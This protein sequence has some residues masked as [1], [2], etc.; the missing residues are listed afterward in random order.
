[1][2]EL[3][4]RFSEEENRKM[5][6]DK[7]SAFWYNSAEIFDWT[8]ADFDKKAKEMKAACITIVCTRGI[9]HFR[10]NY[11]PFWPQIAE[12]LRKAVIAFHR[13]GIK[14][15][16]HHS[17][18]LVYHPQNEAQWDFV[19]GFFRKHF[20]RMEDFPGY[21]ESLTSDVEVEKGLFLSSMYQIDGS[22]G[23]PLNTKYAGH[24][25]C[26]NNPDYNR[27]YFSHL[28]SI[29]RTGVDCINPDDVMY[30]GWD[31]TCTC[32]H[33]RRLFKEETGY[34]LP[35]PEHWNEFFE[36]YEKTEY[37][38]WLKFKDRSTAAFQTRVSEKL[39]EWGLEVYRPCYHSCFLTSNREHATFFNSRKYWS[40]IY[41]E[42]TLMQIIKYSWPRFYIESLQRYAM[43]RT[44]N[45]PSMS[46]FY[47]RTFD[48]YFFSWALSLSWGQIPYLGPQGFSMT[49][50]DKFFNTF[51]EN[52]SRMFLNQR[53]EP[54]FAFLIP[55]S[56]LDFTS[57]WLEKSYY[58]VYAL[59]EAA[60][61]A[62]LQ[63]DALEEDEEQDSFDAKKCIVSIGSTL[64]GKELADKL[65]AYL[66]QGGH[67]II[68][69]D[70]AIFHTPEN[71]D[72]ILSH[73]NVKRFPWKYETK[74][75]QEAVATA[76]YAASQMVV[77]PPFM[78]DYLKNTLGGLLRRELPFPPA[79]KSITSGFH[80]DLFRQ[81]ADPRRL[82]LHVLDMRDLLV[83]EGQTVTHEDPLVHFGKDAVRNEEEIVIV[84]E[85]KDPVSG[86]LCSPMQKDT[87]VKITPLAEG[88]EIRIPVNSF[89]GYGA[90]ELVCG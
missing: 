84:L 70:F 23:A 22:T 41:Q 69:G 37:V 34:D 90:I 89:A 79:V 11:I 82:T 67:L 4:K 14:V 25:L 52:H 24:A 53:K 73:P 36:H 68:F 64:V 72:K 39:K 63:A 27:I 51:E 16:D 60:H 76:K 43:A 10:W 66:N 2:N 54:D 17:S 15:I 5:W 55:R 75:H 59:F 35:D 57:T 26:F 45:V 48:Q 40:H 30:Y 58:P 61:F 7:Y 3:A 18:S 21:R 65:I 29:A 9:T 44:L 38:A 50:E 56:S 8:Q 74:C 31:K 32:R 71:T 86:I 28:E 12:T 77:S 47:P 85:R 81:Y 49:D 62:D 42:N 87:E 80:A 46:M 83:P 6:L 78:A 33:C 20:S 1:M 88:T 13:Q 19:N